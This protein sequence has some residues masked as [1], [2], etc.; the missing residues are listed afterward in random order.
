M[1]EPTRVPRGRKRDAPDS[2]GLT[3]V[4]HTQIA[5]PCGG[6]VVG[7][8]GAQWAAKASLV[9][10]QISW[11]REGKGVVMVCRLGARDMLLGCTI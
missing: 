4:Q 5:G 11:G 3:A 1:R 7:G 9:M 2:D 10:N 8:D 6:S